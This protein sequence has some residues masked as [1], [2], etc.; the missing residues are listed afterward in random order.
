MAA[1]S[2]GLATAVLAL[3]GFAFSGVEGS[4]AGGFDLNFQVGW[5]QNPNP[6]SQVQRVSRHRR[7]ASN[8]GAAAG[9][10]PCICRN[11]SRLRASGLRATPLHAQAPDAALRCAGAHGD[12]GVSPRG[13]RPGKAAEGRRGADVRRLLVLPLLRPEAGQSAPCVH[14][15]LC[16]PSIHILLGKRLLTSTGTFN[17]GNT[18]GLLRHRNLARRPCVTSHMWSAIQTASTRCAPASHLGLTGLSRLYRARALV[19]A[20]VA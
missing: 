11:M 3:L 15:R 6:S 20:A 10:P 2:L 16:M 9:P 19:L 4:S 14:V 7:R 5:L 12:A 8:P 18:V 17:C 1:P 13:S